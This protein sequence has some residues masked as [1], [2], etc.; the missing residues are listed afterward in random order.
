MPMITNS[1][2]WGDRGEELILVIGH[3]VSG[4]GSHLTNISYSNVEGIGPG[5]NNFDADPLFWN[6]QGN[7]YH[8][9]VNSPAIGAADDGSD[10]GAFQFGS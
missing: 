3:K 10:V 4:T 9:R 7:N 1:I 8:L 2:L 6:A 5:N